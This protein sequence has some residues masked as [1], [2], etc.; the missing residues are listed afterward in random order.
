M[1]GASGLDVRLHVLVALNTDVG[2]IRVALRL[3]SNS[4]HVASMEVG[5]PGLN[6]P[7]VHPLA[8]AVPSYVHDSTHVA[9]LQLPLYS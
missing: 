6:I 8:W 1:N 5:W 7:S 3:M 2:S 4:S 9:M